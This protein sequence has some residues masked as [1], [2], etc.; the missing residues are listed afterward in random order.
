MNTDAGLTCEAQGL[1]PEGLNSLIS[2]LKKIHSA[3]QAMIDTL[4]TVNPTHLG[5]RNLL[6]FLSKERIQ[7]SFPEP[8]QP[9]LR[10]IILL[11]E[12]QTSLS[13]VDSP[14]PTLD[15]A[16]LVNESGD[17]L[18][19]ADYSIGTPHPY[20]SIELLPMSQ[21]ET[22]IERKRLIEEANSVNAG[23]EEEEVEYRINGYSHADYCAEEDED[24]HRYDYWEEQE[25]ADRQG[26][27]EQPE[28]ARR[29]D[30]QANK[31]AEETEYECIRTRQPF[32]SHHITS[33]GKVI[34]LEELTNQHL[35]NIIR[36][37]CNN[38]YPERLLG[39]LLLAWRRSS[40]LSPKEIETIQAVSS[41]YLT[42]YL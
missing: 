17:L 37:N 35:V 27:E 8:S 21:L 38:N 18:G 32:P 26:F 30:E 2:E 3:T 23:Y 31:Q 12:Y 6:A 33:T 5:M 36:S 42:Q 13:V 34:P 25:E 10:D 16:V 9:N 7:F 24:V 39:Y 14:Q 4:T 40:T 29:F 22:Q 11:P 15:W 1:T 28:W 41:K 19:F 20:S